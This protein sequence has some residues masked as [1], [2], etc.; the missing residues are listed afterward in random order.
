MLCHRSTPSLAPIALMSQL[1]RKLQNREAFSQNFLWCGKLFDTPKKYIFLV[2]VNILW[3]V[4]FWIFEFGSFSWSSGS[5]SQIIPKSRIFIGERSPV[6]E[7]HQKL[8]PTP[9][10]L[11]QLLHEYI[12]PEIKADR[13]SDLSTLSTCPK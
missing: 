13:L 11:P 7:E 3:D 1:F 5:M 4:T 6:S 9:V 12:V 10:S 8:V 2:F